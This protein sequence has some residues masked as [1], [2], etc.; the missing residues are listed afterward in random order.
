MFDHVY[1]QKPSSLYGC[2]SKSFLVVPED[3]SLVF[4]DAGEK[5]IMVTVKVPS[6]RKPI[7]RIVQ[8]NQ[9]LSIQPLK[10]IM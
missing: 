10:V 7:T 1:N 8:P 6:I 2:R 9:I 4:W 5:S 3:I